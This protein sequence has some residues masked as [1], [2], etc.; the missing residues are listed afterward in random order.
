[1]FL[2]ELDHKKNGPYVCVFVMLTQVT[3]QLYSQSSEDEEE[4]HEEK[5]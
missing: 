3:K 1:L 2:S 4:Q 5:T